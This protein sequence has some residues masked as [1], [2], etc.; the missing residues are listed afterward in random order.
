MREQTK[1][2]SFLGCIW[3]F[4]FTESVGQYT[5]VTRLK[6]KFTSDNKH[7]VNICCDSRKP[8]LGV[9]RLSKAQA[10]LLSY[11]D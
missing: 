3:Y 10:Y 6:E 8:F 2:L 9:P 1:K 7:Y 5:P 11:R 4:S